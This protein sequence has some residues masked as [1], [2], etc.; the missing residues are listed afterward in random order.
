MAAQ[1]ATV[2]PSA[3]DHKSKMRLIEHGPTWTVVPGQSPLRPGMVIVEA[4][5]GYQKWWPL[6]HIGEQA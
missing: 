1:G 6:T 3:F 4:A 5:D 2:T